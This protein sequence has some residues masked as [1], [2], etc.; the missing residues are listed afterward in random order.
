MMNH[1]HLVA[2]Q[3]SLPSG[4]GGGE[5]ERGKEEVRVGT[6]LARFEPP[7]VLVLVM[8]GDESAADAEGMLVAMRA[9]A[10]GR[11]RVFVLSNI[12]RLGTISAEA[13]RIS[14]DANNIENVRAVAAFGGS[15]AQRVMAKLVLTAFEILGQGSAAPTRFF[16]TEAHARAWFDQLRRG[17]S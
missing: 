17:S 4:A 2:E 7:D 1:R 5:E 13:R 15:F 14:A 11:D 6:H 16:D 10:K 3:G 9:F 12:T 8:E